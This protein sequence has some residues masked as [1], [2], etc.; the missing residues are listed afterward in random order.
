MKIIAVGMNYR[1]HLLELGNPV[2]EEPVLFLKP[3]SSLTSARARRPSANM[4]FFLPDFSKE[5]H[6]EAEIVIRISKLGKSIEARFASRYYDEVTVGLDLTARDL[7]KKLRAGGMPWEICKGFD[8]SA[9]VGEFVALKDAGDVQNLRFSLNING[10]TVQTG[11]TADMIFT[12][13]KVIE[14][15]SRFFT[16]K[17]GDLI[18]TGTP[19]GIGQLYVE[20]HLEGFLGEKKLLDLRIK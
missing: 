1:K 9:V 4:P 10:K 13:D 7:Q 14:Y 20:D 2:P 19:S 17:T 5:I 8:Q 3:D 15:A 12:V 6:Y 11:H 18:Y 16:L